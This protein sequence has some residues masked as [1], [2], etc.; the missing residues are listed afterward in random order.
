MF[1]S[2]SWFYL[3][4]EKSN[5]NLQRQWEADRTLSSS[6]ELKVCPNQMVEALTLQA[7]QEF[8]H[9]EFSFFIIQFPYV[10][11]FQCGDL[12]EKI[13]TKWHQKSSFIVYVQIQ[14]PN[15]MLLVPP[16]LLHLNE[17]SHA[18]RSHF[19]F[20]GLPEW[21]MLFE[22]S[23]RACGCRWEAGVRESR[24]LQGP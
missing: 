3:Y 24:F 8:N 14:G 15:L 6:E 7:M 20:S 17:A 10:M 1:A 2:S 18:I 22:G 11:I 12:K 23:I 4:F 21:L 5:N 13:L 9:L 16:L 19:D